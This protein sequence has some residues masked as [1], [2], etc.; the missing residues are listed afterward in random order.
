[1]HRRVLDLEPSNGIEGRRKTGS[2]FFKRCSRYLFEIARASEECR[3][4]L[5]QAD[6]AKGRD[7]TSTGKA[8]PTTTPSSLF[9]VREW[10]GSHGGLAGCMQAS[11]SQE[12]AFKGISVRQNGLLHTTPFLEEEGRSLQEPISMAPRRRWQSPVV[13]S[14]SS[15]DGGGGTSTPLAFGNRSSVGEALEKGGWALGGGRRL[16]CAADADKV[17]KHGCNFRSAKERRETRW[18]QATDSVCPRGHRHYIDGTTVSCKVLR[19]SS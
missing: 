15:G 6:S 14:C 18:P 19:N 17:L 13:C 10:L 7:S 8:A 16:Q 12:N 5:S 4:E 9:E 2:E 3:P 11:F 1:V